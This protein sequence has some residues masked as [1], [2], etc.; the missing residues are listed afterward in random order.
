M[1][2]EDVIK[3]IQKMYPRASLDE[4]AEA[5]DFLSNIFHDSDRG[6]ALL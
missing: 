4:M 2:D 6:A 3:L 1:E 5:T